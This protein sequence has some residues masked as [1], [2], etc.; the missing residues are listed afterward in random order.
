MSFLS[1]LTERLR[2]LLFRGR[3][4]REMAEELRFHVERETA[5]RIRNGAAPESA[6]REALLAFGG[7]EQ[8]KEAV[9]DARAFAPRRIWPPTS[10]TRSAASA[11]VL[12]SP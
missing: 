10:V 2:A 8:Y 7:V 6:R 1:D 9:R 4:E 12:V 11:A 3:A 5:E